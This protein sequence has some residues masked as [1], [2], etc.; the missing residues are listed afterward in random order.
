MSAIGIP[1]LPIWPQYKDQ[2]L[3]REEPSISVDARIGEE[4]RNRKNELLAF[5]R[6]RDNWD[7]FKAEAPDPAV[8]DTAVGYLEKLKRDFFSSPP[9]RVAISPDG[10]VALEWNWSGDFLRAEICSNDQITWMLALSNH[11]TL[12]W[13]TDPRGIS[14]PYTRQI[15]SQEMVWETNNQAVA[16][17]VVFASVR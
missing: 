5:R 7:G 13:D 4:W 8:I 17:G 12:F 15:E 16:G 2:D 6:Y 9:A 14:R 3:P 11:Q 10:L 1:P